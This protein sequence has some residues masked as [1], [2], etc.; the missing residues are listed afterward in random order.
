[1]LTVLAVA[2]LTHFVAQY[3]TEATAAL[4]IVKR[5]DYLPLYFTIGLSQGFLPLLAYNHSSGNIDRRNHV[6][7]CGCIISL[8]FAVL[9]FVVYEIWA[10]PLAML[11]TQESLTVSYIVP[12]LRIQ[13]VAMPF[14]AL[15]YPSITLFQAMERSREALICSILRKGVVDIPLLFALNALWPLFGCMWVQPI[16]DFTSM[17]VAFYFLSSLHLRL[18]KCS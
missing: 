12:F 11:F 15:C 6:F 2:A 13:V 7:R 4:G 3:N 16:V 17:L 14:M 18:R 1:M 5:L 8:C 10:Y 9:C